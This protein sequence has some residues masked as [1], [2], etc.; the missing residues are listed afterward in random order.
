MISFERIAAAAGV[1]PLIRLRHLLPRKKR[2]GEG[3]SITHRSSWEGLSIDRKGL[4]TVVPSLIA[5][6]TQTSQARKPQNSICAPSSTTRF[7]GRRKKRAAL[8]ALRII[9]ANTFSRHVAMPLGRLETISVSRPR[10]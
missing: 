3:L 9:D 4:S 7:G 2:G 10:K 1:R 5:G 6:Y 8:S